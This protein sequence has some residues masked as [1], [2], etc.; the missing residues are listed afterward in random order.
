MIIVL[1]V[2]KI[3]GYPQEKAFKLMTFQHSLK[4]SNLFI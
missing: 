2:D 3:E 1:T 4:R